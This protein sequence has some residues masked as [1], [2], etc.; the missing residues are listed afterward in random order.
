MRKTNIS[1]IGIEE[2]E[3][4]QLKGPVNIYNKIIEE[5]FSNLR[6]VMPIKIKGAYRTP[7]QLGQKRN[8]TCHIIV[9]TTNAQEKGKILKAVREKVK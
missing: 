3:D 8:S 5:N 4:S 2:N 1:I 6:K 9:I 7:N